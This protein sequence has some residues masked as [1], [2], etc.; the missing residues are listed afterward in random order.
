VRAALQ[1]DPHR[2]DTLQGALG[3]VEGVMDI[4]LHRWIETSELLQSR[5]FQRRLDDY[6]E[7]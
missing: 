3:Y 1:S 2:F 7:P 6:M 4:P 5:L